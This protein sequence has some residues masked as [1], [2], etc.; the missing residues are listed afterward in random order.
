MACM[1]GAAAAGLLAPGPSSD[2]AALLGIALIAVGGAVAASG[3]LELQR[4]AALTPLPYPRPEGRLV[5]SGAY[6]FVRHPIYGGLIL[7]TVGWAVL[8]TSPL[9]FVAAVA[10]AIVFDLKRRREEAWLLAHHPG[11]R[12]YQGRTRA[13]IPGLY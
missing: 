6:R 3:L 7:A 13:L 1:A 8:R 9:A 5:E 10:L 4:A 11:Y 2:V 12:A